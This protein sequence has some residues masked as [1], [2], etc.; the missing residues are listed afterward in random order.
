M[1][2]GSID[3]RSPFPVNLFTGVDDDDGATAGGNEGDNGERDL[4][5]DL[6]TD[7]LLGALEV[8]SL[9]GVSGGLLSIVS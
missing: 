2:G 4:R 7:S 1:T 9:L 3:I 8:Y 6:A 5:V